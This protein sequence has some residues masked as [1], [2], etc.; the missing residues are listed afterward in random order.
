MSIESDA[1]KTPTPGKK[2]VVPERIKFFSTNE[3]EINE[4]DDRMLLHEISAKY[5][6]M[7]NF[8]GPTLS[9]AREAMLQFL[10]DDDF[11]GGLLKKYDLDFAGLVKTMYCE[12]I[13]L[14][15]SV[16][17]IKKVKKVLLSAMY[18]DYPPVEGPED[19]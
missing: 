18:V 10:L 16:P 8:S 15:S 3:E 7:A 5:P 17:F 4:I 13:P 14:L 12:Y 19:F 11:V 6:G 2:V 9:A 1:G